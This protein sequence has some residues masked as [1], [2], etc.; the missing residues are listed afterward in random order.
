MT[1]APT[2]FASPGSAMD[3]TPIGGGMTPGAGHAGDASVMSA[4]SAKSNPD[5]N[6]LHTAFVENAANKLQG[7]NPYGVRVSDEDDFHRGK[8][9]TPNSGGNKPNPK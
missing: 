9:K 3:M 6:P 7:V 2:P 5:T 8:A 4:R 1:S